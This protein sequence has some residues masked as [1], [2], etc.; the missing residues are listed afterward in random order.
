MIPLVVRQS[1]LITKISH[2]ISIIQTRRYAW[3]VLNWIYGSVPCWISSESSEDSWPVECHLKV[4]KLTVSNDSSRKWPSQWLVGENLDRSWRGALLCWRM[5]G[6]VSE[7]H[8]LEYGTISPCRFTCFVKIRESA[9]R[10]AILPMDFFLL[11][12]W[13]ATYMLQILFIYFAMKPSSPSLPGRV[14]RSCLPD[15]SWIK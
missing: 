1:S 13:E 12:W 4:R 10:R 15:L 6:S 9:T 7:H 5:F 3:W 14:Q 11:S 8:S 2:L